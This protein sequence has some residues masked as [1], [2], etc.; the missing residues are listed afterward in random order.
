MS[1]SKRKS[2]ISNVWHKLDILKIP[3]NA[4]VHSDKARI[5]VE[6]YKCYNSIDIR[7]NIGYIVYL[8]SRISTSRPCYA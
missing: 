7:N 6:V 1:N 8:K 5:D 2:N 3:S 4:Q